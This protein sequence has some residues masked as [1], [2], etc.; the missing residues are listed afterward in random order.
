MKKAKENGK[1]SL[2]GAYNEKFDIEK[3]YS[4]RV[5][6]ARGQSIVK[7]SKGISLAMSVWLLIL[8]LLTVL[9]VKP[10]T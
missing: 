5:N 1:E 4:E 3:E 2:R 10:F 7:F 9:G 6:E 8:I